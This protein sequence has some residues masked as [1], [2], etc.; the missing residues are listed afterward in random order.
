MKEREKLGRTLRSLTS[1]MEILELSF[2]EKGKQ[3]DAVVSGG[4]GD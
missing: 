2:S 1:E 4:G 3:S